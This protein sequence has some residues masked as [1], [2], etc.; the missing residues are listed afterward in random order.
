[1]ALIQCPHCG[2]NV[3]DK[4][5]RCPKCNEILNMPTE[6]T[7]VKPVVSTPPPDITT[8][9]TANNSLESP[10]P[11]EQTSGKKTLII[12]LIAVVVVGTIIASFAL[13][14]H[15][16]DET[17][18]TD[19]VTEQTDITAPI[20]EE[21]E[22]EEVAQPE[23]RST[24]DLLLF[25][26][27]GYP[28]QITMSNPVYMPDV[29]S[30]PIKFNEDGVWTNCVDIAS[31][32][33]RGLFMSISRNNGYIS[34]I[35]FAT[36]N[37]DDDARERSY[38]EGWKRQIE[39]A[40][41]RPSKMTYTEHE[42]AWG[43]YDLFYT[44]GKLVRVNTMWYEVFTEHG[45]I[46]VYKLR[47]TKYDDKGNWIERKWSMRTEKFDDE[48]EHYQYIKPPFRGI[49]HRITSVDSTF[50]TETRQITY[51]Q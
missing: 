44:D 51:Y 28:K 15:K 11:D 30:T 17:A 46:I 49:K 38:M 6:T 20:A 8:P 50:V 4:A 25:D 13:S 7:E 31:N 26:I 27:Q 2:A 39:W 22:F 21:E 33:E 37:H 24:P 43:D 34:E 42:V 19:A 32:E 29:L 40:D 10:I 14:S 36:D 35:T 12:V 45:E 1:M 3:S 16:S 18:E 47:D 23:L 5:H 41:N 9:Q 48:A